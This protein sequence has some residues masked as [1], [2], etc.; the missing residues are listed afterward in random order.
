MAS[1]YAQDTPSKFTRLETRRSALWSTRSSFDSTW[2]ELADYVAPRRVRFTTSDVN[3]GDRRTKSIIDSTARY[4]LRTLGSGM[5]AGL[6][7]PARPWMKLTTHDPNLDDR[8]DIK[9]WL[10]TVTSRML[11]VFAKTNLYNSLPTIYED[12]GLFGTAVMSCLADP[13]D[14]FRTYTYPLGS[15]AVALDARG[16]VSTFARE[17]QMTV[18]TVVEE[19]A[20]LENGDLNRDVLSMSVR[21][22]W[23]R[24]N[25]EQPVDVVWMV[26]PNDAADGSKIGGKYLPFASCY[27]ERNL[28]GKDGEQRFL[29]ESGFKSN[30]IFVPR[31]HVTSAE[32]AY[33]TDC[34]GMLTLGD[35]KQLQGMQRKEGQAIE[36]MVDPPLA[37]PPSMRNQKVSLL[38]GDLTYDDSRDAGKGVRALHEVPPAAV[39]V[40]GNNSDKVRYRIQRG[41]YEDLFLMLARSDEAR[42][43]Q[44]PTAREVDERHEEKLIALGPVLDRTNDELLDPLVDRVFMIMNEAGMIPDA[45]QELEGAEIKPE[46]TSILAQAQ[47]LLGVVSLDRFMTTAAN[48]AAAW[49]EAVHKV[50]VNLAIDEY[51]DVLGINPGIV[52]TT[53][54]AQQITE[55]QR[56][57][58]QQQAQTEQALTMA[59]AA[60]AASQAPLDGNTALTNLLGA[61]GSPAGVPTQTPGA[62]GGM[63]AGAI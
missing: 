52:R 11:Q 49:P 21:N 29:R 48:L 12:M 50:D 4:S 53:E 27:Y 16:V 43:S 36:K 39:E 42:G 32:D 26:Y 3:R 62:A 23:D 40:I 18:R 7:S 54:D 31:W 34:P 59:K 30:P 60:Q 46:Y 37:G 51:R 35:V 61:A 41:F 45:P 58:A 15:F 1:L 57:A 24:G 22:A 28:V 5:H 44:P 10:H 56:Q 47:K 38:S 9:L 14:L 25:Y 19:F 55:Q 33:G 17:W 2:R 13:R 8:P 20:A 63:T 6:T